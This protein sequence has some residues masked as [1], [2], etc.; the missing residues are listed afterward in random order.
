MRADIYWIAGIGRGRLA[1]MPRPRAGEW[2]EDEVKA[3]RTE[4]IDTV[5]SLLTPTETH[6]LMLQAE[7]QT[8]QAQNIEFLSYPIDDRQTPISPASAIELAQSISSML[9]HGRSVAIHCRAGIGRSALFAA[10][11]MV[12]DGWDAL[13][14]FESIAKARGLAVP[15]TDSQKQ[16]VL[17]LRVRPDKPGFPTHTL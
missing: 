9:Q 10:T 6:E 17:D 5:V 16:W 11:V 4:G 3:W 8:C 15:D 14:A 2:L 12:V 7:P 13:T 1:I